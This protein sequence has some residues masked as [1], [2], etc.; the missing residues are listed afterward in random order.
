MR[1]RLC[2]RPSIAR[3][4]ARRAR[5]PVSA[6]Q[7]GIALVAVLWMVAVLAILVGSVAYAVRIDARLSASHVEGARAR[8]AL[9][10]GLRLAAA[11]LAATTARPLVPFE[12]DYRIGDV[13]VVVEVVRASGFISINSAPESLLRDLFIHGAGLPDAQALRLAQRVIDWRDPDDERL[14]EGAEAADYANEGVAHRPRNEAFRHPDDIGQVLGVS[15]DVH[16][17]IRGLITASPGGGAGAINPLTAPPEVLRIVAR[18]DEAVV[19]RILS[20]RAAGAEVVSDLGGL[21]PRHVGEWF[22]NDFRLRAFVRE[23][24]E[25]RWTRTAWLSLGPASRAGAGGP[26]GHWNH[27]DPMQRLAAPARNN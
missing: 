27:A 1:S 15:P 16:A 11:E 7:S 18:G 26:P 4:G 5:P 25:S 10:G 24:D 23:A 8:A 6:R 12:L 2:D 14:P 17:T 13:T 20:S 22:G 9:D 3:H 19:A 21:D